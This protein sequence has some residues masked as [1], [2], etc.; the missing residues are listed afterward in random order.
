MKKTATLIVVFL[1]FICAVFVFR[2]ALLKYAIES[3]LARGGCSAV[4]KKTGINPDLSIWLE[5]LDAQGKGNIGFYASGGNIKLEFKDFWKKGLRIK[6]DLRDVSIPRDRCGIMGKIL[7]AVS[8]P[9]TGVLEFSSVNGTLY[10][11]PGRFTVGSFNADGE[12]IRIKADGVMDEKLADY[13]ITLLFSRLLVARIPEV[14]SK[15]FF[16]QSGDWFEADIEITGSL[17]EPAINFRTE[18]FSL[19]VR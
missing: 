10:K 19:N 7:N 3:A 11:R 8:L 9:D 16:K 4:V 18:L 15:V 2:S 5:G 12:L 13:R 6:F 1:A 14:I 17:S